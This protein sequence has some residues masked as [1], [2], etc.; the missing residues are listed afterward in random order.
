VTVSGDG[1]DTVTSSTT[2]QYNVRQINTGGGPGAGQVLDCR[3]ERVEQTG[4][5]RVE[6]IFSLDPL[7]QPPSATPPALV[8]VYCFCL[9]KLLISL[10]TSD[11]HIGQ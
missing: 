3:V 5:P 1:G 11:Q 2:S 8:A 10:R 9:A 4:Q 7:Q 6:M